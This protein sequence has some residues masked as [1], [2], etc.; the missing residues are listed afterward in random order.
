MAISLSMVPAIEFVLWSYLNVAAVWIFHLVAVGVCAALMFRSGKPGVP[1]WTVVTALAWLAIVWASGIDLQ[2]GNRLF[3]SVLAYDYNVRSAVIDG[4]ASFEGNKPPDV[5][6]GA[7]LASP[8]EFKQTEHKSQFDRG[9][10]Y[11]VWRAIW[12]A[13]HI[14]F[15]LVL[16][17]LLPIFAKETADMGEHYGASFGLGVLV[18]FG[19]PIAAII[20]CVTVIGL[21]VGIST[22]LLWIVVLMASQIVVGTIVG[23]WIMGRTGE[24]WPLVARM[25]VGVILVRIVTSVPFIGGWAKFVV[26]LWGM[27]AISLALYRRLQPMIAPNIPSV[28]MTPVGPVGAKW[29]A[30]TFDSAKKDGPLNFSGPVALAEAGR[31]LVYGTRTFAAWN[32]CAAPSRYSARM[33]ASWLVV[34]LRPLTSVM[35]S[36]AVAFT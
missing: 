34:A 22:L 8:M 30:S 24:F 9:V 28:P 31:T 14:L 5:S 29:L 3:P 18:L 7:K 11:Y 36:K 12:T 16:F 33:D 10:G 15:G 17:G 6:S 27:G 20:V 2:I 21:L 23:Q 13:T 26:I 4:K 25:A 1:R 19:V 35:P 32:G